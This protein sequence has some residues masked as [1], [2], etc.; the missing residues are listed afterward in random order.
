MCVRLWRAL[1]VR[2]LKSVQ[3][4]EPVELLENRLM[5]PH[6]FLSL[7]SIRV[8]VGRSKDATAQRSFTQ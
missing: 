3:E 8:N 1:N 6:V 2:I 4:L 5:V 7:V